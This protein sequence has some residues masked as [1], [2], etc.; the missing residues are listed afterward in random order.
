MVEATMG[1]GDVWGDL[2]VPVGG[3]DS[4]GRGVNDWMV[5]M[6]G[7]RYRVWRM[8][9]WQQVVR[10]L[11]MWNLTPMVIASFTAVML[12]PLYFMRVHQL[13]CCTLL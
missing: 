13:P 11:E 10:M 1:G 5:R 3:E 4:R 8:G 2:G 6:L 9:Q 7:V 12:Q